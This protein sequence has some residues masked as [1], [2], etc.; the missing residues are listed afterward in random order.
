MRKPVYKYPDFVIDVEL[1]KTD[2]KRFWLKLIIDESKTES[3]IFILKNPSR[4]NKE[5][6]D[7]TVYNVSSYIYQNRDKY[8]ALKG[9]GSVIILN[10]IPHYETYSNKLEPLKSEVICAEN[11]STIHR[12]SSEHSKVVIAW[13]DHPSGLFKEYET[14]K[15]HVMHILAENYNKVFY[16]DKLSKGGNPKHGQVWGYANDLLLLPIT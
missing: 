9:I 6:S 11:L 4:A 5:V 14:L 12:L 13:G 16:V 7:K 10:L 3:I 8:D 1:D 15:S 2:S